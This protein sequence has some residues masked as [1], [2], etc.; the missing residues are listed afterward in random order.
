MK[1][2]LLRVMSLV[3]CLAMLFSI[4][5]CSSPNESTVESTTNEEVGI[6]APGKYTATAAGNNGDMKI[7]VTFDVNSIV[8]VEVLEH[9]ES[10]GLSDTPIER[11]T[12][13]VVEKQSLMIDTVAGATMT[14]NALLAAIEDCIVQAEGDVALFKVALE[15]SESTKE[16]VINTEVVVVGAGGTGLA[17][18]ASAFENGAEVILLEKLA[19]TGGS[20]AL[21]GGAIAATGT[22]FQVAQGIEDSKESW[23][24]LWK[25]RQAIG[26]ED[27][28][29][30]NYD[31]VDYFMDEAIVTTEWLADYIGFEYVTIMGFGLDPVQRLHVGLSTKTIKGGTS[32]TQSIETFL[33]ENNVPIYTE[34]KATELILDE[35]GKVAGV[36]AENRD[37]KLI[38]NAKKVILAT[39]GFAQSPELIERFVPEVAASNPLSAASVGSTGDGIL[40]AEAVGASLHDEPWVIGLGIGSK[41]PGLA[42]LMMDWTK[43]YVN[44]QGERFTNEEMHYA[45]AT[46]ELI[47]QKETWIIIDSTEANQ[48]LIDAMEAAMPT[49]E[50]V[51]ADTVEALAEAMG[52]PVENLVNTMETFNN[53]VETGNDAMGKS[54]DYLVKVESAPYYAV[55]FY[56]NTMGTFAGVVTNKEF[57]VLDVEG[58]VIENLYAGGECANK[59]LYNQVYM[60][61]SSIQFALTSGRIAGAHAANTME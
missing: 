32:L 48:Y 5:A 51:K 58:N 24:N 37:G 4:T 53:G 34:T 50:A 55:R 44:D 31:M 2:R 1:S 49:E 29:Y 3:L 19:A 6:F 7:E 46:N 60:T 27:S 20:T 8:S 42:A 21:S 28:K 13:E 23:M 61:G 16:T 39:G 35:S 17:A 41:V 25:E 14:S 57:Q 56:P 33:T 10:S 9:S 22:K 40:M 26:K 45:I 36:L 18:A 38:I 47:K 43:V 15:S 30:P 12:K 54:V 11:I 52:V 59:T